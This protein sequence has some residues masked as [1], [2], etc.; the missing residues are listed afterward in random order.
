MMITRLRVGDKFMDEMIKKSNRDDTLPNPNADILKFLT[1]TVR[2]TVS[3]LFALGR[4]AL[5]QGG[6]VEFQLGPLIYR[7]YGRRGN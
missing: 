7:V 5:Q 1:W 3:A 4:F 6:K 2:L